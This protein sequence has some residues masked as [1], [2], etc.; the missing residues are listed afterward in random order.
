M[1]N[2][3]LYLLDAGARIIRFEAVTAET[4]AEAAIEAERLAYSNA[5]EIWEGA[6]KVALIPPPQVGE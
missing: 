1:R 6:R 4:D 2:Y 5:I 3:R